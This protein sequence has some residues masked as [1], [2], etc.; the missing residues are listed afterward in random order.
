MNEAKTYLVF[1]DGFYDKYC[2]MGV[3][4]FDKVISFEVLGELLIQ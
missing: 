2:R 3:V 4:V 1:L